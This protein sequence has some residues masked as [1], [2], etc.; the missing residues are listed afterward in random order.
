MNN[1]LHLK[2]IGDTEVSG[3]KIG[4][5][6]SFIKEHL[7][8]NQDWKDSFSDAMTEAAANTVEHA[9]S[10]ENKSEE[11]KKWW[12][13]A[14][15]NKS[16]NELS[17]VFYDQGLGILNTLESSKKA[18]RKRD[19]FKKW[20]DE[21]GSKG[22]LLKRLVNTNLSSTDDER[23][24]NGL[25]SFKTFIDEVGTG[26]LTIHTDNVSYS[27]ISD[28]TDSYTSYIMGTLI[29][30]KIQVPLKYYLQAA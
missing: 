9:Y 16:T 3:E 12:L 22:S 28:R 8:I 17:F 15:L 26:E 13:S 4:S 23:R 10:E 1:E 24:G 29:V 2:I 21:E 5:L 18:N 11:I 7:I 25:I 20:I 30:W 14:S 27:A 19:I 6:I